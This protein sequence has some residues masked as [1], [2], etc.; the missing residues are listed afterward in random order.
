M[1]TNDKWGPVSVRLQDLEKV[2]GPE[3]HMLVSPMLRLVDLLRG[4]SRLEAVIP[5]LSHLSVTLRLSEISRYVIA[6]YDGESSGYGI[7]FV[8]PP[9]EFSDTSVV[10]EAQA[11][12]TIVEYLTQLQRDAHARSDMTAR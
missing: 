11:V 6:W 3:L 12:D 7:S 5:N 1:A 4:D 9:F 10:P 2:H 8:D